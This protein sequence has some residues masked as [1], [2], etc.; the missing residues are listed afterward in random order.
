MK[1]ILLLCSI[2]IVALVSFSFAVELSNTGNSTLTITPDID[3]EKMKE[4]WHIWLRF[5]NDG[6]Q[7]NQLT[8][9]LTLQ[10][11][12]GQKKD[13]CV[14]FFNNSTQTEKVRIWF[15]EGKK[16]SN[17]VVTYEANSS[18]NDFDTLIKRDSY[19]DLVLSWGE[20]IVK[21]FRI[22]IPE[23]ATGNI[24]GC[25]G[26]HLPENY[27][28][29]TGDIFGIII[30]KAAPI[31]V[32]VTWSVYKLGRR[33]DMKYAYTDNKQIILKVLIAVLAIRL[34]VT[35]IKTDKK[36]DTQQAKKQPTKK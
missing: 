19:D 30:R 34:V 5:C 26:Y 8:N 36:K 1:K 28:Q 32:L 31:E 4:I 11:Q 18:W 21:K 12:P 35:I 24:Y 17:W 10:M 27:S 6:F 3:E 29:K 16:Q 23:S 14:V 25:L 33:D 7:E 2:S 13:I 20:K 15:S 9:N 22:Y